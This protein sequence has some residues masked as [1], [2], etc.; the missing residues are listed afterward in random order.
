MNWRKSKVVKKILRNVKHYQVSL[1]LA[2]VGLALIGAG[3]SI[4]KFMGGTGQP[5]FVT[6][7]S[8]AETGGIKVDI[9]GAVAQPG[10][11]ALDDS[12]RVAEAIEKAGNFTE[13]ADQTWIA[14]N[15]NLAAKLVDGQKI[16]IP[17]VGEAGKVASQ[18]SGKININNA[19]ASELDK[20]PDIGPVRAEKIISGRPYARIEDLLTKKIVGESTFE[21]IKDKIAVY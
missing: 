21:K 12:A 6:G 2:L 17:Q 14:Q 1:I 4:S 3:L 13:N 8:E 9:E 19:Q 20:L 5:Q 16:Y 18:V 7:S 15:L 10:V 11:Y